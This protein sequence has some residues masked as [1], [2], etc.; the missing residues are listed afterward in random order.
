MNNITA[1]S[2]EAAD[3]AGNF[4]IELCKI[5]DKYEINR[6]EFITKNAMTFFGM[7]IEANFDN[8]ELTER[9]ETNNE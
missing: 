3:K 1:A 9:E 8:L 5:A 2:K 7:A 4:V 6:T